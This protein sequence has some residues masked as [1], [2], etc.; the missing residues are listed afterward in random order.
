MFD[1]NGD[2][3]DDYFVANESVENFLILSGQYMRANEP[4]SDPFARVLSSRQTWLKR[5]DNTKHAVAF[6]FDGDGDKDLFICNY[7][8]SSQLLQNNGAGV[9]TEVFEN[10]FNEQSQTV[11]YCRY[12]L[13]FDADDDGDVDLFELSG[14]DSNSV[15]MKFWKNNSPSAASS[16]RSFTRVTG[17]AIDFE[18]NKSV[19]ALA[20]DVDGD[21]DLDLFICNIFVVVV[22]WR[23]GVQIV[24]RICSCFFSSASQCFSAVLNGQWTS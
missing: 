1:A 10:N 9:F 20:I 4:G 2:G 16:A 7:G 5:M 15:T 6:D 23:S 8:A 3:V 19:S 14:N 13:A 11:S 18:P 12:A 21:S 17:S 22:L 24:F